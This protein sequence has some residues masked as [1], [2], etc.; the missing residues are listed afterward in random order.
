MTDGTPNLSLAPGC[1]GLAMT[2]RE[3]ARE[4]AAC[5]FASACAPLAESNLATLRAEL[6]IVLSP[7]AIKKKL[8]ASIK[9]SAPPALPVKVVAHIA[10]LDRLGIKLAPALARG[11]NPFEVNQR[12]AFLR[13]ACHLLLKLKDGVSRDLLAQCFRQRL[14]H[15]PDT[16]A[17][18]AKQTF[19]ILEAVGVAR[20]RNGL[21]QLQ[22]SQ[23][24]T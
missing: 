2:Y 21:L 10:R 9:D 18:H 20:E 19:Q 24:E 22:V 15:S 16:A 3:S 4:C 5:P 13:I 7:S 17:A 1:F 8:A 11:E 12:P 6:G 14:E 23:C